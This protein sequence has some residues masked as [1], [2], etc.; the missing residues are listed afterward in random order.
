MFG[1]GIFRRRRFIL[2]NFKIIKSELIDRW[3]RN[4]ESHD[5]NY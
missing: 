1:H 3:K 2:K 4:L 5:W